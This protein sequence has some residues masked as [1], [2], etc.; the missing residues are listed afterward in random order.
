M[1]KLLF[2]MAIMLMPMMSAKVMADETEVY[3]LQVY[4]YSG[5]ATEFALTDEP[6][7][8]IA[9]NTLTVTAGSSE[10]SASL[11]DVK[12]YKYSVNSTTGI[13]SVESGVQVN[14]ADANVYTINGIFVGKGVNIGALPKGI[15]I[16]RAGKQSFKFIKK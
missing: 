11:E 13:Q 14:N 16:L 8:K 9:D 5:A 12:Y 15:Y 4:D 2:L 7:I 3:Y 10:L 6:V 1:K